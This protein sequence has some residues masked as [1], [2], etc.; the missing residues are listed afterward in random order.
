MQRRSL[1]FSTLAELKS[2]LLELHSLG[3]KQTG[4]W[5]LSQISEH[6]GD[7]ISFPM[8]GFPKMP[9]AIK[10][11]IGIIRVTRGKSLFKKFVENQR[12]PAGQPTM[13]QTVHLPNADTDAE[14]RSVE[15]LA[16]LINR[17]VDFNGPIHPSPLFGSLSYDEL[18]S[19]Q[20]AHAAHH[21][22]FLV[23]N[24]KH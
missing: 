2:D 10:L 15:R 4:K 21:L 3:Y 13:T 19:L 12:M 24:Q 7:W 1:R 22:S 23:P 8:D 5:D 17:L 11:L 20:L 6:L 9:F 16:G 14:A 18:V